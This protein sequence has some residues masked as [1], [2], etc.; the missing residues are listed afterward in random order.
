[1]V[2]DTRHSPTYDLEE[3]QEKVR[4]GSYLLTTYAEKWATNHGYD[5]SDIEGCVAAIEPDDFHKSMRSRN[6]PELWQDVYY[7]T[8]LDG[9]WYVKLQIV[10][11]GKPRIVSFKY[12]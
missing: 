11:S 1:M 5:R 12:P 2:A 3:I 9:E 8:Y 7:P 4:T 6:Q 10:A